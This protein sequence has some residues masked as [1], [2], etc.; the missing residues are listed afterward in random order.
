MGI[1]IQETSELE[2]DAKCQNLSGSLELLSLVHNIPYIFPV[3]TYFGVLEFFWFEG[4]LV[5]EGNSEEKI[6]YMLVA[7]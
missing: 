3:K 7:I 4:D 5:R 1:R 2:I 6:A